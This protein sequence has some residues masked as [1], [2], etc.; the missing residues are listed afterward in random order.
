MRTIGEIYCEHASR[1][2]ELVGD[3]H[4][5]INTIFIGWFLGLSPYPSPRRRS[6]TTE[7]K[8]IWESRHRAL[9]VAKRLHRRVT[10]VPYPRGNGHKA[11]QE[12]R[13]CGESRHATTR[14]N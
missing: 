1:T 14:G 11:P 8:R 13:P 3:Y 5:S 6:G 10:T 4:T 2:G 12:Y 9:D 7:G